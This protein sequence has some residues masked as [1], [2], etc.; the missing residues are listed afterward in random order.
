MTGVFDS[1]EQI[2]EFFHIGRIV[3]RTNVHKGLD[4]D[5]K[6]HCR[7]SNTSKPSLTYVVTGYKNTFS[8]IQLVFNGF[9]FIRQRLLLE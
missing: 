5:A 7:F 3:D 4:V 8:Y 6:R 1:Y 2:S 9:L